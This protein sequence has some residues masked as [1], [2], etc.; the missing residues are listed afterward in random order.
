MKKDIP[1]ATLLGQDL[2][3][4]ILEH[5]NNGLASKQWGNYEV[6][7]PCFEETIASAPNFMFPHFVLGQCYVELQDWGKVI[8]C[9]ERVNELTDEEGDAYFFI[10]IAAHHLSD[11]P[12]AILHLETALTI[13]LKDNRPAMVYYYLA[14]AEK[15]RVLL[16]NNLPFLGKWDKALITIDKAIEL[17][18]NATFYVEKANILTALVLLMMH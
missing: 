8:P 9:F 3:P 11:Y 14:M 15:M 6:A 2:S 18:E 10:G 13:G 17:E 4:E 7:I 5:Y 1:K 16:D 12:K